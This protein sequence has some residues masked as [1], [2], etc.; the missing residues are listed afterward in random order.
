MPHS[1]KPSTVY[2]R[3]QTF[4]PLAGIMAVALVLR[5]IQLGTESLWTDEMYSVVWAQKSVAQIMANASS[6]VHPP[7]YYVLLHFWIQ[8]TGTSETGIRSLSVVFSLLSIVLIYRTGRIIGGERLGLIA[9]FLLALSHLHIYYA[10]EARNYA[11]TVLCV[12]WGM[13]WFFRLLRCNE[14]TPRKE[15]RKTLVLYL[16]A[17]AA[18]MHTHLFALFVTIAQNCVVAGYWLLNMRER[19]NILLRWIALQ[20]MLLVCFIPW[21]RILLAQILRVQRGFWIEQPT[22]FTL[23]E[24]FVEYAGGVWLALLSLVCMLFVWVRIIPHKVSHTTAEETPQKRY[25]VEPDHL[26]FT[27]VLWCWLLCPIFL[28][29]FKSMFSPPPVYYIKY[30]IAALPAFVLLVAKGINAFRGRIAL[31]LLLIIFLALSMPALWEEWN[32]LNKERWRETTILL[33]SLADRGDA[34]LVHQWY[35]EWTLRYYCRQPHEIIQALPTQYLAFRRDILENL[36]H[37]ALQQKKLWLVLCQRDPRTPMIFDI[38]SN[39]G[40]RQTSHRVIPSYYRKYFVFDAY[41]GTT[42][43]SLVKTYESPHITLISYERE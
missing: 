18:M 6:D 4:L 19:R 11:F 34:I 30:T 35:H 33:D 20:G 23:A 32:T 3:V 38:I 25:C 26:F 7:V 14:Q 31:P 39:A 36:A 24:T 42:I 15:L 10:Q 16:I 5:W 21:L 12:L 27:I 22:M 40:F 1:G 29:F 41:P 8:I 43:V 2:Q 9:A 13:E 37:S 28:P 17:N